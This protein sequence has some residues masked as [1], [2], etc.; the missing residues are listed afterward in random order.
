MKDIKGEETGI[1]TGKIFCYEQR[2][3]TEDLQEDI[4][5]K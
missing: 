3:C 2:R 1:K 4:K 5:G